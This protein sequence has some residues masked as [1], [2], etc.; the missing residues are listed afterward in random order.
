MPSL[1]VLLLQG[2][3][4]SLPLFG[5]ACLLSQLHLSQ[6]DGQMTAARPAPMSRKSRG[7][8][9]HA[10]A[11]CWA[12]SPRSLGRQVGAGCPPTPAP[13]ATALASLELPGFTPS[14]HPGRPFLSGGLAFLNPNL[15]PRQLWLSSEISKSNAAD[16]VL[17]KWRQKLLHRHKK[18]F[19]YRQNT[20]SLP[21][22]FLWV[23]LT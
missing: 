13:A 15:L 12:P 1:N 5:E 21:T 6:P 22:T 19:L 8:E 18:Q 17:S 20:R 14:R 11:V 10:D 4:F 2:P 3:F 7:V 23:T 9:C 16:K